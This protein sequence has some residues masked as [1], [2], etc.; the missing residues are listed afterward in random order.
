MT[1]TRYSRTPTGCGPESEKCID[2]Q[3]K[4]LPA[5]VTHKM[6]C[7]NAAR[8][9]GLIPAAAPAGVHA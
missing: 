5:D 7:E 3:F 2:E 9:Y 1:S 6:T 8:F 4:H